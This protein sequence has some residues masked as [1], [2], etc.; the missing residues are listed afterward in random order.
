MGALVALDWD[1]GRILQSCKHAFVDD[2]PLDDVTVPLFA[3]LRGTKLARTL[4][5]YIGDVDIV[6][7]WQPYFCVSTNLSHRCLKASVRSSSCSR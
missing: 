3:L 6:D 7:L 4:Q 5:H 1:D 2:R